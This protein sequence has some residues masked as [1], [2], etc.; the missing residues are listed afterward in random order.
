MEV[1][2]S[3]DLLRD[4]VEPFRAWVIEQVLGDAPKTAVEVTDGFDR[5][6]IQ[7]SMAVDLMDPLAGWVQ[8]AGKK[9]KIAS[10]RRRAEPAS[11]ADVKMRLSVN[12]TPSPTTLRTDIDTDID[13]NLREYLEE[14]KQAHKHSNQIDAEKYVRKALSLTNAKHQ[15]I[16]DLRGRVRSR[17]NDLVPHRGRGRPNKNLPK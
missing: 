15:R 5:R 8:V 3:V 17:Y 9:W 7:H 4:F 6:L 16:S 12:A 2:E 13:H 14:A 10:L 1:R 11:P